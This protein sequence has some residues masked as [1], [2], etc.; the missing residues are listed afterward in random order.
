MIDIVLFSDRAF[1]YKNSFY[2]ILR[3]CCLL[4]HIVLTAAENRL[5]HHSLLYYSEDHKKFCFSGHVN[6]G[7]G[8]MLAGWYL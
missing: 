2:I 7:P 8:D 1:N 5:I 4:A 6:Y 3:Q